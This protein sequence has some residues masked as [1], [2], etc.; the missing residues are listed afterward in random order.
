VAWGV[1]ALAVVVSLA[2]ASPPTLWA[3]LFFGAVFLTGAVALA[4]LAGARA[5]ALTA[6]AILLLVLVQRV[7]ER[8][9]LEPPSPQWTRPLAQPGHLVRH[10]MRL[11]VGSAAWEDAWGRARGAYVFVCARSP[12]S[13]AD[14]LGL[15]VNGVSLGP[16]TERL[17]SG[18]RPGP[19]FVGF[20]RIPVERAV[21]ERQ[22]PAV[23]VVQ[24]LQG[25]ASRPVDLCGTFTLRPTAGLDGSR[26]F[27]GVSW[28]HPG[29][30]QGGRF[31]V[32]LR[33]EDAGGT[34]FKIWY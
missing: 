9:V 34:P 11:P 25:A 1:L 31:V 28:W 5:Q 16:I 3:R 26:L 29:P 32:E 6:V 19:T 15:E 7:V 8:P 2:G 30:A 27:D 22:Q 10:E 17:A 20:Y 33:L 24:R 21:L 23:F 14:G 4:A 18:P 13:D 12:L